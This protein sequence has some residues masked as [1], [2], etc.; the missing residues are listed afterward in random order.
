MLVI[1]TRN[2]VVNRALA[3]KLKWLTSSRNWEIRLAFTKGRH[4][5]WRQENFFGKTSRKLENAILEKKYFR[6]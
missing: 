6:A 4:H 5:G 3:R 1:L 2:E